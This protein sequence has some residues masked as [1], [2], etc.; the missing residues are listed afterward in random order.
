LLLLF[1]IVIAMLLIGR[2]NKQCWGSV[3]SWWLP[4]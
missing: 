1:V 4:V 2:K 3:W